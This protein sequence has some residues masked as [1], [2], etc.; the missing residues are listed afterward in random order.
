MPA[1]GRFVDD[2]TIPDDTPILGGT[3]FT[4]TWL[5]ENNGNVPWSAGFQLVNTGGNPM[6]TVTAMTLPPV[7]PGQQAQISIVMTAPIAP[8]TYFTD[9]RFRDNQGNLFGEIIYA[10]ILAKA[11]SPTAF[12][13]N[14]YFVDDITVPDDT[15][16]APETS[17]TKT[18]RVRNTGTRTWDANY[19]LNFVGGTLA[20]RSKTVIVTPTLPG[21]DVD[22]SVKFKAP[23]Q[24]GV[25]SSDWQMKDRTGQFFGVKLWMR[26]VVPGSAAP[27]PAAPGTSSFQPVGGTLAAPVPVAPAPVSPST[28]PQIVVQAKAPHYS[29]RDSRWG[30]RPLGNIP[31]APSISRWGCMMTCFAMTASSMGN[32]IDPAQL[33]ELMVQRGGYVNGYFTSW[34]ALQ[35][36]FSNIVFDGKFD[37]TPDMISRIDAN[38][39]A[40]RPVPVLVDL[41]PSNAYSDAD[42]H[43]VLVVGRN[44]E[45]FWI[46]DP[47]DY[48]MGP[49]SLRGRYGRSGG[50]L[51]DAIHSAILYRAR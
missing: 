17:F 14:N 7:Q 21:G 49:I 13:N 30:A 16:F 29:Q 35:N 42:Q 47:I 23:T 31:S 51:K 45:D 37:Q 40:G 8:G 38:L 2:V 32:V 27:V 39:Q 22:I 4:K 3:L 44:G 25:Y 15:P 1:N 24:P 46:N 41:S 6:T 50:S 18:W 34:S 36:V 12:T 9:W 28:Q 5:V 33:N 26:I 48:T 43:W 19:T 10:R 11:P 20:P